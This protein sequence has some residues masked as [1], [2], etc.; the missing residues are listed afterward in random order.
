MVKKA[1]LY[2]VAMWLAMISWRFASNIFTDFGEIPLNL[3]VG[4]ALLALLFA[5][6]FVRVALAAYRAVAGERTA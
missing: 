3:T 1:A 2:V 4:I 6:L 5:L